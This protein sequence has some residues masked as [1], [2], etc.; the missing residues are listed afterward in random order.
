MFKFIFE[1]KNNKTMILR[2]RARTS[3]A[4]ESVPESHETLKRPLDDIV[5][6]AD[7]EQPRK[8]RRLKKRSQIDRPIIDLTHEDASTETAAANNNSAPIECAICYDNIKQ[9][10]I[11]NSCDHAFC[12]ECISKWSKESTTCPVCK[13][14]FSRIQQKDLESGKTSGPKRVAER[15][16][17]GD[18]GQD[19]DDYH[20]H[21]G[22]IIFFDEDYDSDEDD[23][24]IVE[25]EYDL[26]EE[27]EFLEFVQEFVPDFFHL[28]GQESPI[29]INTEEEPVVI[30]DDENEN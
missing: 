8:R 5:E 14:R 23:D 2:H 7:N 18:Y 29:Y 16:L 6:N 24:F 1:K 21:N 17:P 19:Y 15:N 22:M 3:E 4:E 9:Q 13:Q 10:G 11:L 26:L 20:Q 25:D 27:D 28:G 12:H 30:S